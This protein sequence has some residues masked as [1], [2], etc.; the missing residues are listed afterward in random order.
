MSRAEFEANLTAKLDDPE[1][2]SDLD[3]L[4]APGTDWDMDQ[5]TRYVREQLLAQLPGEPWKGGANA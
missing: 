1:F 5:A 2:I 3:P 4:L